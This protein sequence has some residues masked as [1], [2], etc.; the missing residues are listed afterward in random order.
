MVSF[1]GLAHE[2]AD[3]VL[4]GS[5]LYKPE[6]ASAWA[7]Y[8]PEQADALLDEAGL[9]E[10]NLAGIRLLPDGR[11]M[12]IIVETTGESTVD[13]DVLQL[14][15]DH[16][17]EV[18]VALFIRV[19]QR[20]IFRS[21]ALAGSI[22]MSAWGGM[23]NGVP[24]PDMSPAALAPTAGDLLMWPLWGANYESKGESGEAP[25]MPE[26]QAQLARYEAWL[27]STSREERTAIWHEMLAA[28]TDNV[29]VIGLVNAALQPILRSSRL[30]NLPE[31]GLYGFDPT[32][33]L[34][35]YM[36]DTFWMDEG[37]QA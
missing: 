2:S 30:Q 13:S 10:R 4:P 32:S 19:S 6:Y 23:D 26:A 3:S 14:V 34:G 31:E 7:A 12:N 35:V 20:D 33:Y 27:R 5:A 1:F 37:A 28:H 17:R 15:K 11:P 16:W 36:P 29:F 21:R 24:T 18:G 8:D 22:V 25:D 9:G